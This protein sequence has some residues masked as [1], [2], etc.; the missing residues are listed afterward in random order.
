[1]VFDRIN[2]AQLSP[3]DRSRQSIH[4]VNSV[5]PAGV[6]GLHDPPLR[7]GPGA[8]KPGPVLLV[9][10]IRKDVQTHLVGP[11]LSVV[12]INKLQ[13]VLE[14]LEPPLLLSDGVVHF[15]V[16]H[17]P[18]LVELPNLSLGAEARLVWGGVGESEG[19][20]EEGEEGEG[21]GG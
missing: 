14:D 19:E 13:V 11:V 15:L 6:L 7:V 9:G 4:G 10:Q 16:L 12:F 18:V 20:E 21:H 1:M 5:P 3:V 17:Q 8:Q 2:S